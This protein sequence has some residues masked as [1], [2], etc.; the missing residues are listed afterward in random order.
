MII[1]LSKFRRLRHQHDTSTKY[2]L[3]N[4]A[5]SFYLKRNFSD[6]PSPLLFIPQFLL[7]FHILSERQMIA[8]FSQK[9]LRG[10]N[11]GAFIYLLSSFA[12]SNV[13]NWT[14]IHCELSLSEVVLSFQ[15]F[16]K[17]VHFSCSFIPAHV[18]YKRHTHTHIHTH[19][20]THTLSKWNLVVFDEY[21]WK[22][23]EGMK[24]YAP[25]VTTSDHTCDNFQI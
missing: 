9:W 5:E 4:F 23:K 6:P 7:S 2:I 14:R 20:Y 16:L 8:M 15:I 10:F 1:H 17:Q 12:I 24:L 18:P 13:D 21:E 11:I 22:K 25:R 3:Q 19:K